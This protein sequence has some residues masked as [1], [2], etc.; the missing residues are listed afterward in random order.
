MITEPKKYNVRELIELLQKYDEY[1]LVD[2]QGASSLCNPAQG[3]SYISIE[4]GGLRNNEVSILGVSNYCG[5]FD[6]AL[7]DETI[8]SAEDSESN[9][10]V[11]QKNFLK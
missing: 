10:F 2:V 3:G 11:P 6:K 9:F 8:T 5:D 7:S 1:S 4:L